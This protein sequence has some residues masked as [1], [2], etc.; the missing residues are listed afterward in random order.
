[1]LTGTGMQQLFA[2]GSSLRQRYV[3]N[4]GILN[5]SYTR[6]EV[7]VRSTSYDRTLMSAEAL[8][9][10][11]YPPGTGPDGDNSAPGLTSADLQVCPPAPPPSPVVAP[12][13]SSRRA[14]QH[15]AAVCARWCMRAPVWVHASPGPR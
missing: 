10:G 15:P 1:M 2:V 4:M 12:V 3:T 5:T 6:E 11:L 8:L 9:E 14:T 7:A 13:C